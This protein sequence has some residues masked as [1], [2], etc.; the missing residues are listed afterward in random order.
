MKRY[1]VLFFLVIAIVS[2]SYQCFAMDAF[3]IKDKGIDEI[4]FEE[5]EIN[6]GSIVEQL[7]VVRDIKHKKYAGVIAFIFVGTEPNDSKETLPYETYVNPSRLFTYS[8]S[9][10]PSQNIVI[11]RRR[12]ENRSDDIWNASGEIVK[13][14]WFLVK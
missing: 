10:S 11:V 4:E 12:L 7:E 14:E 8:I 3:V 5:V 2:I 1:S 13:V 9:Y 6:P